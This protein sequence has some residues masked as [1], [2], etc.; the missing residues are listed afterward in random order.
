MIDW[1]CLAE[2]LS[3]IRGDYEPVSL[4]KMLLLQTWHDLSDELSRK[5]E[6][7]IGCSFGFVV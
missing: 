1:G 2:L 6:G 5:H 7:V 3:G 4:F